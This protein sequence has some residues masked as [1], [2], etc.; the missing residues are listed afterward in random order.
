MTKQSH[1]PGPWFYGEQSEN[2]SGAKPLARMSSVDHPRTFI[3]WA[4]ADVIRGSQEDD[5]RL[6]AAAPI[7]LAEL[8]AIADG[9]GQPRGTDFETWAK[10]TARAAIAKVEG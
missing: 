10:E 3:V 6:I 7:M 4:Y 1:T 2:T 9:I 8:K 5:A